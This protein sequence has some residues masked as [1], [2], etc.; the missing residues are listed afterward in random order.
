M[1]ENKVGFMQ[2]KYLQIGELFVRDPFTL[3]AINVLMKQEDEKFIGDSF[4]TAR[5]INKT[6]VVRR[7]NTH[8][9]VEAF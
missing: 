1:P 5:L 7:V 2:F 4:K 6:E 9:I 8:T 3:K